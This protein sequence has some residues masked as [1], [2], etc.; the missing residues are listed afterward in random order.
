[1]SKVPGVSPVSVPER[2]PPPPPPPPTW[3]PPPPPPA[4]TRYSTLVTPCGTVH[5][6]L[7]GVEVNRSTMYLVPLVPV[8]SA[9]L[10]K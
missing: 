7:T 2:T 5:L 10:D 4:T 8:P 3:A 9:P 6:P 1:M